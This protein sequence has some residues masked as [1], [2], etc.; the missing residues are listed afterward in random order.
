MKPAEK[1]RHG[2]HFGPRSAEGFR[3]RVEGFDTCEGA[4]FDA[5]TAAGIEPR[6]FARTVAHA[7]VEA[8]IPPDRFDL[9]PPGFW[10]APWPLA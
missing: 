4:T 2:K 6:Q 3:W 10:Q 8:G 9:A 7:L 5:L 1:D